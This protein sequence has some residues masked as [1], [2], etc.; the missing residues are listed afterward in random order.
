M[1][2]R[3]FDMYR[4]L[5]R[6]AERARGG[7]GIGLTIVRQ[8]VQL[9]GG[10][11]EA[12]SDGENKGSEFTVRLPLLDVS[13]AELE[14]PAPDV[15]KRE[16]AGAD[17]ACSLLVGFDEVV[18]EEISR[19]LG[20]RGWQVLL[21]RS[22]ADTLSMGAKARPRAVL[23]RVSENTPE[24]ARLCT[25]LRHSSWGSRALV[26]GVDAGGHALAPEALGRGNLD[27]IARDLTEAVEMV[28][29]SAA[30]DVS[31]VRGHSAA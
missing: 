2:P 26:V 4:Q 22:E 15:L 8:I 25:K 29:R 17:A 7:L 18:A 9:H 3:I 12:R 6:P 21:A 16:V 19:R 1:L 5:D 11:I 20:Q 28:S 30:A 14:Y 10:T 23:L 27:L 24:T 31:G 13:S